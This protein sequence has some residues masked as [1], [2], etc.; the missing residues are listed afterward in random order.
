MVGSGKGTV[1]NELEKRGYPIIHFGNMIYEEVERRGLDIVDAE[2]SV[3]H[4][5]RKQEGLEVFAKRV[6]DKARR[7]I[8]DGEEVIIFD[9]LYSWS[10]YKHLAK[11]YGK[12]LTVIAV[13]APKETRWQRA[14]RREDNRRKYTV[15]DVIKRELDEIENMEKGGPIAYADYYIYNDGTLEEFLEKLS[16]LCEKLD[17]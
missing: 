3:R 5:M 11:T 1:S 6:V 4:D 8:D 9:G 16:N 13:V 2:T 10:E 12:Q 17:I 15:A 7:L 14:S